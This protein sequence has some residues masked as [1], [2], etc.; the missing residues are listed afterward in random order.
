MKEGSAKNGE[1]KIFKKGKNRKVPFDH[2]LPVGHSL[3][4]QPWRSLLEDKHFLLQYNSLGE[5]TK[6]IIL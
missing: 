5:L 2:F 6:Y 1:K 3:L 4:D